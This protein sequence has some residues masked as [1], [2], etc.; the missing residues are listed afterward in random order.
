MMRFTDR[1]TAKGGMRATK[2][3]YAILEARVARGGNV[4]TYLGDEIGFPDRA[5]VRVYRPQDEVFNRHSLSSYA[6]V[7]VTLGHPRTEVGAATWKDVAV[8]EVGDEVAR[9]G[10]FV[11]VPM[12]LRDASAI[13]EVKAGTRELS[14]GYQARIDLSD[15]VNPAGEPYDAVMRDLRMNH[16]AIV[17]V[18]RGGNELRIGDGA[19]NWGV[20][21]VTTA[22]ERTSRM[23]DNLQTVVVGDEA[24]ETTAAGARAIEK[25]KARIAA[26]DAAK[27]ELESANAEAIAAK[28]EEIGE[29]KAEV[30]E[31]KKATAEIDIDKLVAARAALVEAVK[32]IDASVEV[33][34]K[35]D[36]DLRTDAVAKRL[37]KDAVKDASPAEILGMFNAIRRLRRDPVADAIAARPAGM[38]DAAGQ[39]DKSWRKSVSDLNAWRKGA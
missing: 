21:P 17:P 35:S 19:A 16:V 34:G 5:V 10:E 6:G 8:G 37:G 38:T 20:S 32:E 2:D 9:D 4:Q 13:E 23:A 3:G 1:V 22:D 31:A 30:A 29:L 28:D 39:A 18:A 7:P 33:E 15:G 11:R 12:I 26:L 25:L 24:V 14:M 27:S 36:D